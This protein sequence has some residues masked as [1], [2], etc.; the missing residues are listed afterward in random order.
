MSPAKLS[1]EELDTLGISVN[2]DATQPAPAHLED[3]FEE[4][5]DPFAQGA[6]EDE[7]DEVAAVPVTD[8]PPFRIPRGKYKDITLPRMIGIKPSYLDKVNALKEQIIAD[9]QFQQHASTIAWTYADLRR[10]AEAKAAELSEIKLRLSAVMLL[11]V[12]QFEVEGESGVTLANH[13]KINIHTEPHLIV[14]DKEAFREWCINNGLEREMVLPWGKANKMLKLMLL[15]GRPEPPG[16][17][18]F[19]RPKVK[20]SKGKV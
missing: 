17:S 4:L 1:A 10:E 19:A 20:F 14:T 12:D 16:A 3:A 6:D 2:E 15:D 18:C 13:D 7:D 5:N 11:M 9:P 8:A